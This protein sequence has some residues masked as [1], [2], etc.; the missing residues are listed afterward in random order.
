[1]C[2]RDV[3]DFEDEFDWE[4]FIEDIQETCK[5]LW[6]SFDDCDKWLG[7][8]DRVLLENSLCYIG[9]SEYCGCAAIWIASKKE[10]LLNTGH[11]LD[12]GTAN[13]CDGFIARIAPRFEKTFGEF[14]RVGTFSNGESVYKRKSA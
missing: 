2:Y 4:D 5:S 11:V 13:L 6:K 12:E 3:S 7:N 8:E 1:M 9:V 10:E 14:V